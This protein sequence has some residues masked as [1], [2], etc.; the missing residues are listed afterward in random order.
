MVL[1]GSIL[2]HEMENLKK[3]KPISFIRAMSS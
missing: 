1:L 2:G 3:S